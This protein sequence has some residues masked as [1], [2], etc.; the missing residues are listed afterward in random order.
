MITMIG[1][2]LHCLDGGLVRIVLVVLYALLYHV[3]ALGSIL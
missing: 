2:E 1:L 3:V